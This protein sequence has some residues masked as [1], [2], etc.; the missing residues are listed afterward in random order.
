[1]RQFAK[2]EYV[3]VVKDELSE[4]N[5]ALKDLQNELESLQNKNLKIHKSIESNKTDISE[6]ETQYHNV[7]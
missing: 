1:M 6:A 4:K 3:D 5:K 2:D 7:E